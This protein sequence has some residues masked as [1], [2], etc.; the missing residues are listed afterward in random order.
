MAWSAE[1]IHLEN[2]RQPIE[3]LPESKPV[4]KSENRLFLPY[5][6]SEITEEISGAKYR[7]HFKGLKKTID[8]MPNTL[9]GCYRNGKIT[10]RWR[11]F[12]DAVTGGSLEDSIRRFRL[13][14]SLRSLW[15][16]TDFNFFNGG[17]FKYSIAVSRKTQSH[18]KRVG[19]D[20]LKYEVAGSCKNLDR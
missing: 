19:Q 13:N 8:I 1:I 2:K 14:E 12:L 16:K 9:S 11:D 18:D 20:M 7:I 5:N 3:V 6:I 17:R 10:S 4:S 15:A